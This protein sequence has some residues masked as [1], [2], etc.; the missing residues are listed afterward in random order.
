MSVEAF[1]SEDSFMS[2][3]AF[4]SEDSFMSVGAAAPTLCSFE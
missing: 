3:E 4:M 2:V 1:M